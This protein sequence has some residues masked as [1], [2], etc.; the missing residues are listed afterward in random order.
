MAAVSNVPQ[1]NVG[2]PSPMY[3]AI[4]KKSIITKKHKKNTVGRGV[5]FGEFAE[6]VV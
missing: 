4:A 1:T 3:P 2:I 5:P 6:G